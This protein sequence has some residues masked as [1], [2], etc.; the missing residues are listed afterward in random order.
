MLSCLSYVSQVNTIYC[1]VAKAVQ[2]KV[3]SA[4]LDWFICRK[5]DS[6]WG[7]GSYS[8]T[9]GLAM[10]LLLSSPSFVH[11]NLSQLV[12]TCLIRRSFTTRANLNT[13]IAPESIADYLDA[14][15][16]RHPDI[17]TTPY[18]RLCEIGHVY[19]FYMGHSKS[20]Q[21]QLPRYE[22][23]YHPGMGPPES[24]AAAVLGALQTCSLMPDKDHSF[25]S[26]QPIVYLIPSVTQQAHHLSKDVGKHID[27]MTGQWIMARYRQLLGKMV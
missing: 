1:G 6:S 8:L 16:E 19:I 3:Y 14:F 13:R 5:I 11:S 12:A 25:M 2:L 22:F 23:F 4:I 9:D 10:S 24:V 15:Q 7:I 20:P 17:D 27:S 21:Q 26:E 18:R